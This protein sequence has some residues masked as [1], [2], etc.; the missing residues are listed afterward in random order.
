MFGRRRA[1]FPPSV[2][3]MLLFLEY[4]LE[5]EPTLE[6]FVD[7]PKEWQRPTDFQFDELDVAEEG[8]RPVFT[9][10]IVFGN[11]WLLRL[12]FRDVRIALACPVVPAGWEAALVLPEK[13]AG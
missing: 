1:R 10:S 4:E 6:P 7:S 2:F 5:D 12:R 9:Q 3:E 8:D 13:S 11:G